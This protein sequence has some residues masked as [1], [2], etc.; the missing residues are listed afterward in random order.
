VD[1]LDVPPAVASDLLT[2]LVEHGVGEVDADNAG[3]QGRLSPAG[4]ES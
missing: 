4:R 1:Q 3:R 2:G